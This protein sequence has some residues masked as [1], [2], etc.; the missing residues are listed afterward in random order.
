L[1]VILKY[2]HYQRWSILVEKI[3]LTETLENPLSGD[4]FSA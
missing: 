4:I 3:L 1:L 2:Q